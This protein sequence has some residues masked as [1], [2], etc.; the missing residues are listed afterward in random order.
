LFCFFTYQIIGRFVYLPFSWLANWPQAIFSLFLPRTLPG[1]YSSFA[2]PIDCAVSLIGWLLIGIV[3][4]CLFHF[5]SR[6]R[7]KRRWSFINPLFGTLCTLTALAAVAAGV[8][9]E[10]RLRRGDYAQPSFAYFRW[11]PGTDNLVI[12]SDPGGWISPDTQSLLEHAGIRG[13]VGWVSTVGERSA[14]HR[15][16]V[17]AQRLP[18][19]ACKIYFP[20][21]RVLIYVY[22]GSRWRT[23]PNG[24][25]T[26][27]SFAT[28]EP[29]NPIPIVWDHSAGGWS[30]TAAFGGWEESETNKN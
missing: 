11:W 13:R 18:T 29:G 6:R 27:P 21:E 14:E 7:G 3:A 4:A 1:W 22:D 28:L 25:T 8:I 17:L 26:F 30:G 16:I 9:Y 2:W 12:D 5:I 23:I 19:N 24:A 15:V 20:R 10:T